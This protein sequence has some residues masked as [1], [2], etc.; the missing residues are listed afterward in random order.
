MGHAPAFIEA[1]RDGVRGIVITKTDRFY[2]RIAGGSPELTEKPLKDKLKAIEA[3]L[4]TL[5]DA[6]VE[7]KKEVEAAKAAY[8]GVEGITTDSDEFKAAEQ[9]VRELGEVKD[10]VNDLKLAQVG[11]LKMLGQSPDA[12]TV[13]DPGSVSDGGSVPRGW[14]AKSVLAG[15]EIR[16]RLAHLANTKSQF[17]ALELGQVASREVLKTDLGDTTDMRRGQWV[18]IVP[19]LQR[20]LR[21]LDLL[22]KG[23]TNANTIPYTQESGTYGALETAEGA[24]KPQDGAVYTDALAQVETI[25]VW[26]KI[27]KQFLAD[28]DALQT[29]IEGRL[30]YSVQRRL[31]SQILAGDGTGS[32]LTGLIHTPGIQTVPYAGTVYQADQILTGLTQ[33]MLA[34][35]EPD[36]VVLNPLDWEGVLTKKATGDGQYFSGGP[37][38]ATGQTIWGVPMVP[39]AAIDA[40]EC[41]AG[42]FQLG[43]TLFIRQGVNVLISDSDA[44]DFVQNRVTILAEMRAALAVWQPS[45]FAFIAVGPAS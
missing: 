10:E 16:S 29:I 5:R 36:A 18:G 42:D 14:D 7:K 8:G 20:P 15:E 34:F 12:P 37:F 31:E 19:Q 35:G 40:G 24:G 9:A 13:K 32:N 26:Q 4:D 6:E 44:S 33:I 3:R 21:V 30:R 23:T 43:A 45:I 38:R 25:A 41:L 17:G 27:R 22:P 39:S 2:P 28:V 11:V 1:V